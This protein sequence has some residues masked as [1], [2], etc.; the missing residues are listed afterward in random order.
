MAVHISAAEANAWLEP[1]KLAL[2]TIDED[3]ES[4]ITIMIFSRLLGSFDTTTWVNFA[5]TPQIVRT[6]IAMYYVAWIYDRA[7]SDNGEASD[8]AERLR[9]YADLT[10][11]GILGGGIELVEFPDANAGMSSPSFYPND[12]SSAQ[13]P[14]LSSDPSAG[15]PSF[16]MGTVF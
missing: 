11:A 16:T 15:P 3:L 12:V 5:S 1:T 4:Q 13:D 7:Y 9:Q 8:Y 10:V 2:T 6:V 14:L